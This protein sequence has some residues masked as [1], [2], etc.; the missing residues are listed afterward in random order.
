MMRS[1][2]AFPGRHARGLQTNWSG[3]F[4]LQGLRPR[5]LRHRVTCGSTR[6]CAIAASLTSS[7]RRLPHQRSAAAR[8]SGPVGDSRRHQR[9][10]DEG[11]PNL[12]NTRTRCS[13]ACWAPPPARSR[14]WNATASSRV[15]RSRASSRDRGQWTCKPWSEPGVCARSIPTTPAGWTSSSCLVHRLDE[16]FLIPGRRCTDQ[17]HQIGGTKN[18]SR[19]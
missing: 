9:S 2:A 17:Q 7:R 8:I 14:A 4:K 18:G 6:N 5:P 1:M 13:P 15:S 12:A 3:R 10:P 19:G 16:L 11:R